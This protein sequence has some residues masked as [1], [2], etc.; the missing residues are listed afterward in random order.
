MSNNLTR[1]HIL[2]TLSLA[3]ISFALPQIVSCATS[4]RERLKYATPVPLTAGSQARFDNLRDRGTIRVAFMPIAPEFNY[5]DRMGKG[6]EQI[7]QQNGVEAFTEG[8][9]GSG[10]NNIH[11][12][13]MRQVVLQEDVNAIIIAVRDADLVAPVVRHAVEAGIVVIVA[14]S[15]LKS[16]P[17]PV[18][19]VVA[20]V[21]YTAN[22]AMGKYAVKLAQGQPLQIGAIEGA[23]GYHSTQAVTGFLEGIR[24][25]HLEV[26]SRMS[27]EWSVCGGKIAATSMLQAHPNI[28]LIWAANDNM[29]IGAARVTERRNLILLGRD[30][31]R[32]A[33]K[34]IAAGKISA[35]TDTN[36]FGM[37]EVAMQIVLD[38]IDGYF[39]GGFVEQ[40]TTIVDRS[41]V[42]KFL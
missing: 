31:D 38:A 21:N 30:G 35:T 3:G 17:A 42:S 27:G 18:H 5:Y 28:G 40:P 34:Q 11:L 29:I 22:K 1:R 14:N 8:P 26:V 23:P 4:A 2:K 32:N 15:D 36:P 16:F 39:R 6:I 13:M 12:E 10:D 25:S 24:D 37:G 33:L 7:A 41:N 9:P 19:A 20:Y